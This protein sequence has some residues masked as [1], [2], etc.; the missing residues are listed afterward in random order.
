[1]NG[2]ETDGELIAASLDR[3]ER[4]QAIFDRH[5]AS[6]Y[7]YLRRRVGD[8]LAEELTAEAFTQALRAR[9]QFD[10]ARGSALPWLYGIAVNLIRMHARSERRRRRAYR[11]LGQALVHPAPASE[12]EDRVDAQALAPALRAALDALSSE[13]R[14]V[15]LLHAWA[16]LSPSEIAEALSIP[17]ALVRK[18]LH[19]AR[20]RAADRL[21]RND[22]EAADPL[23]EL[24]SAR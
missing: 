16:G 4:F 22:Q 8:Q 2:P 21:T 1:M 7:R 17:S 20:A 6:V 18:R 11:L 5:G 9:Q 13:Q 12:I 24:R 10:A 19:R 14:E 3:P 15:L 23:P